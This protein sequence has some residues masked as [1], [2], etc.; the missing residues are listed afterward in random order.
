M[1]GERARFE[2]RCVAIWGLG[3]TTTRVLND[4]GRDGWELVVVW[5]VWHYLKRRVQEPLWNRD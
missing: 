5:S 4:Y 1:E 2:Y 3:E